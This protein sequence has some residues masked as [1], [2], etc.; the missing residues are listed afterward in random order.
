MTGAPCTAPVDFAALVAYWVGELSAAAEAP[1]EEHLFGCASCTRRLDELAALW[2]G[3][4]TA[5]RTFR[6]H[7]TEVW[8]VQ[9]MSD[10][11]TL[12]SGSKDGSVYRWEL[13][14]GKELSAT[15][16]IERGTG[17]AWT[18]AGGGEFIVNVDGAGRVWALSAQGVTVVT[19]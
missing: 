1:L 8:R 9:L 17:G 15:G 4:R 3:T 11:R 16:T 12:V 6:G 10:Q 13:Q 19:P 18:F 7:K 5:V 2:S 14:A